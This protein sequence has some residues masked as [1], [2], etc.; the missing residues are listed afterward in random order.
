[1][2]DKVYSV[3]YASENYDFQGRK[4]KKRKVKGL[5]YKRRKASEFEEIVDTLYNHRSSNQE[6]HSSPDTVGAVGS[7]A[8]P[9]KIEGYTVS[10]PYNKGPYQVIPDN[11][12]E[13]IGK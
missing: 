12:I 3:I 7:L 8:S 2:S 6:Y 11:E 1:M 4:R 10:I 5:L 13:Y 9:K